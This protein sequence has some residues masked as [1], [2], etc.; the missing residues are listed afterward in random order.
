MENL[1][2]RAGALCSNVRPARLPSREAA[3]CIPDN[4]TIAVS[5]FAIMGLAN[6]LHRALVERFL[7]TGAPRDLTYIHAAGHLPN[8]G[9]DLLAPHEGLLRKV[10]GGHWGLMPAL[11]AKISTE[12]IEAHNWPQGVVVGAFRAAATGEKNGLRSR[13]GVGTFIDPRQSGGCANQTA[14]EAGSLIR[15]I[16]Q[17]GEE[18]LN[19]APLA[20]DVALIRGWSADKLGNVSLGMEPLNLSSDMIAMATRNRGGKVLCQ[21]RFIEDDVV[22]PS[23]R[24]AIPGFLID[25][26]I[27]T[28]HPET[29]HRQCEMFDVN[30]ALV[31]ESES[32]AG[33]T[34][35]VAQAPAVPDGPRGWIGRR[36]AMEIADGEVFN[37]GIG[38]PGDAVG[39]ALHEAQ[40]L[41]SVVA[42]IESGL[43]GGVALGGV[44]FGCA[45]FPCARLD[46]AAMFDLYHG[47]GLDI[48]LMGAA[49]IDEFGNINVSQFDGRAIGCGGFIDITQSARRVVF[50][51]TLTAGALDARWGNE[52]VVIACEGRHRKFVKRVGQITFNGKRALE[53]GQNVRVVTERCVF[54]WSENGWT[55]IEV[56][57]GIDAARDIFP[58]LN[59]IPKV[60]PDC[61]VMPH[62]CFI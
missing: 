21:V 54:E 37:L 50:C 62:A 45:L 34:P 55:I 14:R 24:V 6:S 53:L 30:P 25:A 7:E 49:E 23:H 58:H 22:Y 2:T 44:N 27:V 5:G 51:T 11:R 8:T 57:P 9:M 56:A 29:E 43:F 10:I 20:P 3:A 33:S 46:Q 26:L 42:T 28:D 32:A 52:R 40:R 31:N 1:S 13:I 48:A 39:P 18:F 16:E 12:K 19:Y 36:A 4:A 60:A 61:G 59:F 41:E 15:L 38:I 17:D 35:N 47:G